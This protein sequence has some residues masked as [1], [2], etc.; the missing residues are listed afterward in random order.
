M[1][2]KIE[3]YLN[4]SEIKEIV[5]DELRSQ[6]KKLFS[7]SEENTQRLLSNL[8]YAVVSEEVEKIVPNHKE[9]IVD[10]VAK[11]ITEKDLSY[12]LYNF[13]NY[14]SGSAKSLGAKI[15]EQTVK[16]NQQLIKDKVIQSIQNADYTEEA[17]MKF[18]N[19]AENFTHNIYDFV[20]LM[21]A[22][23]E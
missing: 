10:K 23:K 4:Q 7:G 11:L 18:E 1:E 9:M 15:I 19:L 22:K 8:C 21:R 2:I 3:D 5:Q 13:D 12:H 6:V 16:D 14:G 20:E 17:F